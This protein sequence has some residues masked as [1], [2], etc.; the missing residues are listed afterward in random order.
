MLKQVAAV[1]AGFTTASVVM[2]AF[3]FANSLAF[4]FPA[5]MDKM[6]LA[7]VRAFAHTLPWYAYIPVI[8]GWACGSLVAGLVAARISP[9]SWPLLPAILGL[10]LTAAAVG[11]ALMLEHPLWVN[12][13]GLPLFL[14]LVLVGYR[15]RTIR[16]RHASR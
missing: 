5:G 8:A 16:W 14:L 6:D 7:A 10:L 2:M 4:P 3:E 9:A 15:L 12:V 13:V 11:N 1:I